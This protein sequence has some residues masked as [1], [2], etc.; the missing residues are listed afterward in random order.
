MTT[1]AEQRSLGLNPNATGTAE[2]SAMVR[3]IADAL[4]VVAPDVFVHPHSPGDVLWANARKG[5]ALARTVAIGADLVHSRD[6]RHVAAAIAKAL[7]YSRP[8]YLLRM[9]AKD[10][11][12]IE[13]IFLAAS[14]LSRPDVP[15][16]SHLIA[17]TNAYRR[18]F[19]SVLAPGTRTALAAAVEQYVAA[20][21]PYDLGSWCRSVDA[22]SRRA[23]LIASGDL[24][25]AMSVGGSQLEGDEASSLVRYSVSNDHFTLREMLGLAR[26]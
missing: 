23:A 16:P 11:S 5:R 4:G 12:D 19:D 13:A 1:A 7:V 2:F 24:A 10:T 8:A 15:V 17:Q 9:A 22:T 25:K 26:D 18:H 20:G 3:T 21:Q 6:M 14:S